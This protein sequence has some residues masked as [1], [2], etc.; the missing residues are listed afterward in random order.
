M[1]QR[2][3]PAT[4]TNLPTLM[5]QLNMNWWTNNVGAQV[6]SNRLAI[7]VL[8]TGKV[9]LVTYNSGLTNQAATNAAFEDRITGVETGK[10]SLA[11]QT[12]T[13]T[14]FQGLHTAQ[15]N[16]NAYF[17][18]F[19]VAQENSNAYYL[20]LFTNQI[21]SNSYFQA[22]KV[23][24]GNTNVYFE[25]VKIAQAA[26]NAYFE[27]FIVSQ[28]VTNSAFQALHTAQASSNS[29]FEGR[30]VAHDNSNTYFQGLFTAQDVSNTWFTLMITNH[31]AL[32]VLQNTTNAVFQSLFDAQANTNAY[33]EAFKVAQQAFKTAQL[34][35]NAAYLVLFEAQ[36]NTN[37]YFEGF[38]VEQG[39][40]NAYF[41]AF[42]VTQD[43]TNTYFDS[44]FTAQNDTNAAFEDRI[45]TIEDAG[46]I[47]GGTN[48]YLELTVADRTQITTN[49]SGLTQA[50][51]TGV[52]SG[53][54]F[55][56]IT[57]LTEGRIYEWGF[58]KSNAYGT[59][60]LSLAT[61]SLTAT[62][63]GATSNYFKYSGTNTMLILT[64]WGDGSSKS[65]VGEVFVKQITN[66]DM[67]VAGDLY[68]GNRVFINGQSAFPTNEPLFIASPAYGITA[69]LTTAWNKASTDAVTATSQCATLSGQIAA[70]GGLAVLRYNVLSNATDCIDVVATIAG[71]TAARDGTTITMTIPAGGHVLS[72]VV[73]WDGTLGAAFTLDMGTVDM[74]NASALT[75]WGG[76]VPSIP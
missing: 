70:I 43:A 14:Y 59:S 52:V 13:N 15:G 62:N 10:Q 25:N 37:A 5:G 54:A 20:V 11:M 72:A 53:I 75:R 41:E 71:I 64:L 39:S 29:Y 28:G 7:A 48:L 19:K 69:A 8:E 21:N 47:T 58:S 31:A 23:A 16:T 57:T 46:Y 35:S 4:A 68:V 42:K 17:E 61:L 67:G 60:V 63:A 56:G 51:Y 1:I 55:T 6:E 74:V 12:A 9:S 50:Q 2:Y 27:L 24:Q 76:I 3:D 38:K 66:G 65:D 18:V 30:L 33:M 44:M 32:F 40:S 34:A 49:L 36:A 22:F 26:S 73:R 45:A